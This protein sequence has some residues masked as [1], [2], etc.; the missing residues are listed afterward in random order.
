LIIAASGNESARSAGH[1]APVGHPANCPSIMAIGAID[2]AQAITDFSCGTVDTIGQV[3]LVGPGDNVY[4][5][6]PGNQHKRLRGTSMAT[7]HVAGIA[8]LIAGQYGARSWELWARLV[9]TAN[10]LRLPGTDVGSGL[11]QAP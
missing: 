5:S 1:V 3:D 6:W 7:P 4:S 10:R 8:A 11:V 2:E 9:Q